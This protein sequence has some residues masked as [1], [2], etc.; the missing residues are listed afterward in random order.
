MAPAVAP[1]AT[2]KMLVGMAAGKKA[3]LVGVVQATV[4]GD[5]QPQM[6]TLNMNGMSVKLSCEN[7]EHHEAL[8]VDHV[9]EVVVTTGQEFGTYEVDNVVALAP[10]EEK[11][12]MAQFEKTIE[13]LTASSHSEVNAMVLG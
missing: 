11:I 3:R 5:G 12:D 2:S 6:I 4:K 13:F 8:A 9:V 10:S 1:R 7:T